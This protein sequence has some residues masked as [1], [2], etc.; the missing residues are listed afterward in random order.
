MTPLEVSQY[1]ANWASI[2]FGAA[3]IYALLKK[4]NS[5]RLEADGFFKNAKK[6]P[7]IEVIK[8]I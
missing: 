6:L 1:T 8:K 4:S 2:V 7:Q 3:A 5:S